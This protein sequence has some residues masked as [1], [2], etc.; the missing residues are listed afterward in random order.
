[1]LPPACNTRTGNGADVLQVE[2]VA[3]TGRFRLNGVGRYDRAKRF[4]EQA[5]RSSRFSDQT[6]SLLGQSSLGYPGNL[7]AKRHCCR[8]WA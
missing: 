1:A 6:H 7:P 4:P 2:G 8:T 3:T 5:C